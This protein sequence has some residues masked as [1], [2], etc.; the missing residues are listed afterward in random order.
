MSPTKTSFRAFFAALFLFSGSYGQGQL[1][2]PKLPA[3]HGPYGSASQVERKAAGRFLGWKYAARTHQDTSGWVRPH[4]PEVI[5]PVKAGA[6]PRGS[7]A[8]AASATS[9]PVGFANAPTLPTGFLPTAVVNGDFN[10][11]GKADLAISNGGDNTIY[12]YLGNGDGSFQVPEIL[13]TA[14]QSP[15][16]LVAATLRANGH[17]DLIAADGDSNQVEVFLGNGDGT[18]QPAAVTSLP[19]APALLLSGDFNQDGA[20]DIAVGFVPSA[21]VGASPFEVLPGNNAGGFSQAIPGPSGA[22]SSGAADTE[23]WMA[24]GDL[25]K[26]GFPDLVITNSF[27]GATAYLNQAGT[28]FQGGTAFGPNDHA[29]ATAL[30]DVTN[31]GCLDAIEAG[32]AGFLTIATGN[33]DGTFTQHDPVANLGDVDVAITVADVNGDGKPDVIASS[34]FN[35]SVAAESSGQGGYGGYLVSVLQGDGSG[36]FAPAA[37][38][39]VGA[40][41]YDFSLADLKGNGKPDIITVGQEDSTASHLSNDGSGVFGSPPGETIG[42]LNAV[43]NAPDANV[44]VQ[45][46]D[47]NGDGKPD[48]L[49]VENGTASTSPYNL[50]ALLN[51][52]GGVLSPPVRTALPESF[53]ASSPLVTAGNFRAASPADVIYI[54]TNSSPNEVAFLRGNGDGTF[55][56]PINLGSL[57]GPSAV[58]TGDFNQDGKLDFAVW[59]QISTSEEVAVFLGNGDGTFKPLP[60]QEFTPLTS[61]MVYQLLVADIDHDGKPDL[62]IG[63]NG[64]SGWVDSGDDLD[65]ALG[66]GDGSFQR[67]STLMPHFGPV[68]ISDLNHDGYVDLIQ[69]RDPAANITQQALDATGGAYLTGAVTVYLGGPGSKFTQLATYDTPGVQAASVVP[70]LAGDFNGDGNLDLALPYLSGSQRGSSR[71]QLFQ[72]VGDGSLVPGGIAFALPNAMKPVV[73][74]DYRG[75]G[76][77]DLLNVVGATSSIHIISAASSP[78]FTIA[79]N[80]SPLTGTQ[81]SVTVTLALPATT[82]QTVQLTSSDPKVTLP[83]GISFS[84][85]EQQQSFAFTVGT[86]FD[87]SHLL[88]INATLGGQTAT[89]YI[90]ARPN[91]NLTPGV[92]ASITGP[93]PYGTTEVATSPGASIPLFLTLQ[94]IHG[95]AG[96]FSNFLC[97]D[98]PAAASCDFAATSVA[99]LP[100]GSAQVAFTVNAGSATPPGTYALSISA[101]NGEM[102]PSVPLTFG[103]GGFTIADNPS[104]VVINGEAGPI[105]TVTATFTNGYFTTVSFSCTGLPAGVTCD[106][107]GSVYPGAASTPITLTGAQTLPAKDY[108]FSITGTAGNVVSTIPATMR[109]SSFTA[110]LQSTT[111]SVSSGHP[112]TF[113]ILLTSL[114]HFSNGKIEVY[115]QAPSTVT[116]T[117]SMQY[118]SLSDGG[119]TVIPVTVTYQA[120]AA[121]AQERRRIRPW[122]AFLFPVLLWP[123]KRRRHASCVRDVTAMITLAILLIGCSGSSSSSGNSGGGTG[124]GGNGGNTSTQTIN[125]AFTV[126]AVN[127]GSGDLQESA[128][129]LVLSVQ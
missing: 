108:P 23:I 74:G 98:L 55:A 20:T 24:A 106:S 52:G 112:A 88:A 121:G 110:A 118:F 62:V 63:H 38:Y 16:W 22:T 1:L 104:L 12:V 111:V 34:A 119:T 68:V 100:G 56:T 5:P 42:Y 54:L 107:P 124:G 86:G 44:P 95:Y 9:V 8:N 116:C 26:D 19:A 90:A 79:A 75:I 46:V 58:T 94:S 97:S 113:N 61:D 50:T 99:L 78:N 18:F 10:E 4:T 123:W 40:Q 11:D 45:T 66:N 85:G 101:A 7:S 117:A 65:L 17:L 122:V 30:A 77:T 47:L 96:D 32:G 29:V 72:G 89:A 91:G 82:S 21:V 59:G 2:L 27:V 126:D 80:G 67:I 76:V 37:L 105:T 25:N 6:H 92:T 102:T 71:L 73:G 35:D 109:V 39:R 127:T 14:G 81:G 48:V 49:L 60:A 53:G 93:S 43:Y 125:V 41:A 33:C 57:P 103:V 31:D 64:N 51:Q 36:G 114:N 84:A 87:Y 28:A 129:T 70:A 83:A 69:S 128:G 3:G 13:Y 120:A 15:I 115:Y